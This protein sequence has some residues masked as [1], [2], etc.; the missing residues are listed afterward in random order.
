[1]QLLVPSYANK[2]GKQRRDHACVSARAHIQDNTSSVVRAKV[3]WRSPR[4]RIFLNQTF[5]AFET[6]RRQMGNLNYVH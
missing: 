4:Q 1:M 5:T 6:A 3:V 2:Q